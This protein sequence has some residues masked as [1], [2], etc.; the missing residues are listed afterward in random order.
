MSRRWLKRVYVMLQCK[1]SIVNGLRVL[2]L[3]ELYF[4]G[5]QIDQHVLC[6]ILLETCH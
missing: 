3:I 2:T 1:L 5:L 4:G 6:I